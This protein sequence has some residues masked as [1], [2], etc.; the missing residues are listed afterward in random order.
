MLF[1]WTLHLISQLCLENICSELMYSF[2]QKGSTIYSLIINLLK[3]TRVPPGG[4]VWTVADLAIYYSKVFAIHNWILFEYNF[5]GLEPNLILFLFFYLNLIFTSVTNSCK[6]EYKKEIIW[7]KIS[8][9]II[10][11]LFNSLLKVT[12]HTCLFSMF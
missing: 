2:H 1:I 4:I 6:K 5:H 9:R 11:S 12:E 7:V 10:R 8:G 3:A